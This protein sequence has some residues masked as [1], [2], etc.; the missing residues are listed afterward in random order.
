LYCCN[1]AIT[2]K[3]LI[4]T[5]LQIRF[6]SSKRDIQD[7]WDNPIRE[8]ARITRDWIYTVD[9]ETMSFVKMLWKF[10]NDEHSVYSTFV[11]IMKSKSIEQLLTKHS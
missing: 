4:M 5:D 1:E 2:L 7:A 8:N 10:L 6:E 3:H 9:P 11:A